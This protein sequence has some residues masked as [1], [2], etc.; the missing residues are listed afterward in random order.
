MALQLNAPWVGSR[1]PCDD[2]FQS[3]TIESV[4]RV[5]MGKKRPMCMPVF[6]ARCAKQDPRFIVHNEGLS[7]EHPAAAYNTV[8]VAEAAYPAAFVLPQYGEQ[9]KRRPYGGLNPARQYVDLLAADGVTMDDAWHHDGGIV[10]NRRHCGSPVMG[11]VWGGQLSPFGSSLLA[12]LKRPAS[13]ATPG[14]SMR[15][16][17]PLFKPS[18]PAAKVVPFA[19]NASCTSQHAVHLDGTPVPPSWNAWVGID[20]GRCLRG[21]GIVV[22]TEAEKAEL[23][24]LEAAV[25]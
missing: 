19:R 18:D 11:N 15:A 25:F 3:E 2:V 14:V 21:E 16:G 23:M 13:A 4:P 7:P 22:P 17:S 20:G 12:R 10:H 5:Y 9:R 24:P 1:R 6:R 8:K